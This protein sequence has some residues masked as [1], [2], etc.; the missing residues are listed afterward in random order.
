MSRIVTI[1]V[2]LVGFLF[3]PPQITSLIALVNSTSKYIHAYDK[4]NG[5]KH[6]IV[7]V[8]KIEI[9]ALRGFLK[10][11]YSIDHGPR[12]MNTSVVILNP[13]EP[14][15]ELINLLSDPVYSYR[16]TY[17]KGSSISFR[18][19]QKAK[20]QDAS[21]V[22]VLAGQDSSSDTAAIDAETVMRCVSLRKFNKNIKIYAEI[23]SPRN[24]IHLENIATQILCIDELKLGMLAQNCIAPGF[25]SLL[26][27]L[28]NSF[29]ESTVN[30]IIKECEELWKKEYLSG[31]LNEVY[32]ITL[33]PL[34]K[35]MLLHDAAE[36][37][38]K[39]HGALLFALEEGDFSDLK[40]DNVR[41]AFF[42]SNREL[43]GG[44]RAYLVTRDYRKAKNIASYR[45]LNDV[46][47]E[48]SKYFWSLNQIQGH[49]ATHIG[50]L[51]N[52]E[53]GIQKLFQKQESDIF[54]D[55]KDQT[56][57]IADFTVIKNKKPSA[58]AQPM[59]E[60]ET[61]A[62]S[63]TELVRKTGI[64]EMVFRERSFGK[65]GEPG[66]SL[67]LHIS[68]HVVICSLDKGFPNYLAYFV[69]P[70]R[71]IESKRPIVILSPGKPTLE[72]WEV[73]KDYENIYYLVGSPLLRLYLKKAL[74]DQASRIVCLTDQKEEKITDR[75][76][77]SSMLLTLLNIQALCSH[78]GPYV[79]VEFVHKLNFKLIGK[80]NYTAAPA[81]KTSEVSELEYED[82]VPAFAAG[83]A[84]SSSMFHSILCQSYYDKDI[85]SILRV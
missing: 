22:F 65:D 80:Y 13:A 76:V 23:L 47:D 12:I 42:P 11:F 56:D 46:L 30:R 55:A 3:L 69:D 43:A 41:M 25:A 9:V 81:I 14:S 24:K 18:S 82:L 63:T 15:P 59:V 36:L 26:Y 16:V 29:T 73:L 48:N 58:L 68:D 31:A 19:L 21:G 1:G 61:P 83:H 70:Y 10:E 84:F 39:R 79:T 60:Q 20:L 54:L 62:G 52:G 5:S 49:F 35:G 53:A 2:M 66:S 75:I 34:Y 77:D 50:H 27:L 32:V 57:E 28:T 74:V 33:S 44:E 17:V 6:H 40:S 71:K 7:I 4:T 85:V 78:D 37:I 51:K 64:I 8:G 45:G 67:P 72:Q 38:F